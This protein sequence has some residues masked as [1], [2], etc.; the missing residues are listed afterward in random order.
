MGAASLTGTVSANN[1]VAR[2]SGISRTSVRSSE[3]V[4][5]GVRLTEAVMQKANDLFKV[6]V[7]VEVAARAKCGIRTAEH[8]KA[9]T[10]EI[11]IEEYL[12]LLEGEEGVEFLDV[13]WDFIPPV[14]RSRWMQKELLSRRLEA[15]EAARAADE[16]EIEQL[17]LELKSR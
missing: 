10:R 4:R 2:R 7:A 8:W 6:K 17:R 16:A 9:G 5:T 3:L 15:K 14:T 13:L 11:G 12:L 1:D